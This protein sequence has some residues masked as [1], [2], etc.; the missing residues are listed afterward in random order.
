MK[1]L[2]LLSWLLL[3]FL[4]RAVFADDVY[5]LKYFF[6]ETEVRYKNDLVMKI[7]V[8]PITSDS[9]LMKNHFNLSMKA[10]LLSTDTLKEINSDGNLTINTKLSFLKMDLNSMGK[11]IKM[12]FG[13]GD[14]DGVMEITTLINPFGKVLKTE[15]IQSQALQNKKEVDTGLIEKNLNYEILPD[16]PVK[17]GDTWAIAMKIP[18]GENLFSQG[19]ELTFPISYTFTKIKKVRGK[20]CAILDASGSTTLDL[21]RMKR[22][23][24]NQPSRKKP[25]CLFRY[26]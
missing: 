9:E 1:R 7:K 22:P 23:I 20:R 13:E 5:T 2:L 16:H 21:N 12:N 18:L 10:K 15:S 11:K 6:K 17:I 8:T 26:C 19:E 3:I 25:R 14:T 4:P 24:P